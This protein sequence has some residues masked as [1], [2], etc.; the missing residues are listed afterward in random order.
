MN[1]FNTI[2]FFTELSFVTTSKHVQFPIRS[3][4]VRITQGH[5]CDPLKLFEDIKR[6]IP[7]TVRHKERHNR[8]TYRFI[9][10]DS[11]AIRSHDFE[12]PQTV[13]AK[14]IR[15]SKLLI[16]VVQGYVKTNLTTPS[17]EQKETTV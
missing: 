3:V 6:P 5:Y 13:S 17:R 14:T 15:G 9:L 16:I 7:G 1:Y 4:P 8:I 11:T 10:E 12:P 2:T